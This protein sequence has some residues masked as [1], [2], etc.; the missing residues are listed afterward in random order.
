MNVYTDESLTTGDLLGVIPG[1][2]ALGRCVFGQP[3]AR[4]LA[5]TDRSST[6]GVVNTQFGW[7]ASTLSDADI[8]SKVIRFFDHFTKGGMTAGV[9]NLHDYELV[10]TGSTFTGGDALAIGASDAAVDATKAGAGVGLITTAT[11]G[12]IANVAIPGEP[13]SMSANKNLFF[14][15][16][17]AVASTTQA[18]M[19]IGLGTAAVTDAI[20]TGDTD[21]IGFRILATVLSFVYAKAATPSVIETLTGWTSAAI[22]S[23]AVAADVFVDLAFLVRNRNGTKEVSIWVNGTQISHTSVTANVCDNQSLTL[24]LA[25]GEEGTNAAMTLKVDRLEINNYFG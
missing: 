4:V 23:P 1:S 22:A 5:T 11:T 12:W 20:D 18:Q 6:A 10:G 9:A 16:R 2:F 25:V 3:V 7:I 13:F 8:D 19:F 24:R 17:V 14:R 15:A 21:G